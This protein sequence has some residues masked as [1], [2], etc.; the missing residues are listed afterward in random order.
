MPCL[1]GS[2]RDTAPPRRA[3]SPRAWPR[4]F[5]PCGARCGG[6]GHLVRPL[7]YSCLPPPPGRSLPLGSSARGNRP[8]S[9][10]E[11]RATGRT[12]G[13]ESG[14][15]SRLT[16][17]RHVLSAR[18]ALGAG[19]ETASRRWFCPH[20]R[21]PLVPEQGEAGSSRYAAELGPVALRATRLP[22]RGWDV[23]G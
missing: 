14:T 10:G 2:I 18:A 11:R 19:K 15:T 13:S 9:K 4:P 23:S 22:S 20:F 12:S 5:L 21:K 3:G 1:L 8:R 7:R 17:S 16:K 6:H